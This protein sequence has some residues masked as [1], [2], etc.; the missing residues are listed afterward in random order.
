MTTNVIKTRCIFL[1]N[2]SRLSLNEL[3]EIGDINCRLHLR[4][5]NARQKPVVP[6]DSFYTRH[7]KRCLDFIVSLVAFVVTLPF[8]FVLGIITFFDVGRPIFFKQNRTGLHG[9]EFKIVKFRN[10][11]NDCD[12]HGELLPPDMRVTGFGRF[13]RRTSLDELLNFWSILKG[14]MSVIGPR[15]LHDC[16]TEWMTERHAARFAVR[17][18][19]ECPALQGSMS[20]MDWEARLENDAWYAENCSLA[21]DIR[22]ILRLVRITLFPQNGSEREAAGCGFF[23]GYDAEG[24]VVDSRCVPD[25]V[26][27]AYLKKRGHSSIL[28]VEAERYISEERTASPVEVQA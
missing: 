15:P 21:L 10:M 23:L 6:R 28:E 13:M 22:L 19:L 17:P 12:I 20:S 16:Y 14:D 9:K 1:N 7:G 11:R 24:H 8:N 27:Q 4:D 3:R 5:A 2:V 25:D 18:G 26:L